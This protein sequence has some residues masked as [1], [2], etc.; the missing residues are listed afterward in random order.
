MNINVYGI[1]FVGLT[2]ALALADKKIKVIGYENDIN[3]INK[4]QNGILPFYEHNLERILKKNLNKY[5]F[6]NQPKKTQKIDLNF[7]CVGTQAKKKS[8]LQILK[9]YKNVLKKY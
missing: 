8:D 4:I 9:F 6:L 1:G 2:T 7:V 3:K 5:F